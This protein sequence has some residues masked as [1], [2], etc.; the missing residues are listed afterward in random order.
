MKSVT[1]RQSMSNG[2][3][4]SVEATKLK[5]DIKAVAAIRTKK[6]GPAKPRKAQA[7]KKAL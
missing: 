1:N 3:K 4:V 5:A 2:K 6:A 7:A